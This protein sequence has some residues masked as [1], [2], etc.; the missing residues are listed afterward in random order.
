MHSYP[1]SVSDKNYSYLLLIH[2]ISIVNLLLIHYY[3]EAFFA[4]KNRKMEESKRGG[5]Y[6]CRFE[7]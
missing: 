5:N 1:S 2:S 4:L 6:F 3:F 7:R